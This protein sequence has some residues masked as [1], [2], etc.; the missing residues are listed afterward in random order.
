MYRSPVADNRYKLTLV[1]ERPYS[2]VTIILI[3]EIPTNETIIS[4]IIETHSLLTDFI[5]FETTLKITAIHS[6]I[7]EIEYSQIRMQ[8]KENLRHA[9][10]RIDEIAYLTTNIDAKLT[11]K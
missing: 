5:T 11:D 3:L 9:S 1:V 2:F 4:S 10:H 8:Q 6:R 7:S